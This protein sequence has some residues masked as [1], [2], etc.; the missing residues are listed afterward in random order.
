MTSIPRQV[1]AAGPVVAALCGVVVGAVSWTMGVVAHGMA[2]TAPGAVSA[3]G[4]L[5]ALAVCA[6]VGGLVA[7]AVRCRPV[8]IVAP[9]GLVAGQAAVHYALTWAAGGHT[10]HVGA[11]G[12]ASHHL[13]APEHAVMLRQAMD[14]V[15]GAGASPGHDHLSWLMLGAHAL[16]TVVAGGLLLLIS[17]W[18]GWLG[19]RLRVLT[20]SSRCVQRFPRGVRRQACRSDS[21]PSALRPPSH[22][23][24]PRCRASRAL[25]AQPCP[26]RPEMPESATPSPDPLRQYG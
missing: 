17:G 1:P 5:A 4:M 20:G 14:A 18:L 2:S 10:A 13:S 11:A 3:G 16:A 24:G 23:P 21:T 22:G 19:V 7:R 12:H 9:A 6:L 8:G 26:T 25:G 15:A